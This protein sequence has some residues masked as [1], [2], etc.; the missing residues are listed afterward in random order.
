MEL[1]FGVAQGF[2]IFCESTHTGACP[3]QFSITATYEFHGKSV[4]KVSRV[5]L[6]PYIGG[7]KERDSVVEELVRIRA[8][9]KK[10][11]M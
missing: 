3:T 9:L 11:V 4:T 6:Q 1:I 8:T 10:Q 5:D 2:L 7:E